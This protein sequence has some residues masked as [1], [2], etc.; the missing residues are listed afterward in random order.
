MKNLRTKYIRPNSEAKVKRHQMEKLTQ[1]AFLGICILLANAKTSKKVLP[2]KFLATNS[3]REAETLL[4]NIVKTVIGA[5]VSY[6]V[7]LNAIATPKIMME[8]TKLATKIG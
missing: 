2:L 3:N 1:V 6:T 4:S 8:M 7:L 5:V